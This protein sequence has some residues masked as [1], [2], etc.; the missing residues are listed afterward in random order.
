M[1]MQIVFAGICTLQDA[2]RMQ[3]FAISSLLDF[4]VT[5]AM[6]YNVSTP[7][8]GPWQT[9]SMKQST[10]RLALKRSGVTPTLEEIQGAMSRPTEGNT[11]N[12]GATL[13]ARISNTSSS[14]A[15]T[16][17]AQISTL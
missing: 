3:P 9:S 14:P 16:L 5:C 12:R 7:A 8:L 11:S 2:L 1:R 10:G 4:S 13:G 17:G 6:K 15:R